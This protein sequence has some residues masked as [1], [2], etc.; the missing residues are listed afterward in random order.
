MNKITRKRNIVHFGVRE[1]LKENIEDISLKIIKATLQIS[2]MK[3]CY[4]EEARRLGKPNTTGKCRPILLKLS[5]K[6]KKE[7]TYN[8][9]LFKGSNLFISYNFSKQRVDIGNLL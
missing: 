2:Y 3:I 7:I 9:K 4:I 5:S 6:N 1:N 8:S